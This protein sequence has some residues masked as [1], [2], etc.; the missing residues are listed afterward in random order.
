[1]DLFFLISS[2]T[3]KFITFMSSNLKIY[4]TLPISESKYRVAP[5][6]SIAFLER[7][8]FLPISK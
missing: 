8:L 2:I 5:I 4:N 7:I 1:M 3:P 6:F